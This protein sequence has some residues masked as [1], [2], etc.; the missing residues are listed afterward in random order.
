MAVSNRRQT[1][2]VSS[3]TD[4]ES[5][6]LFVVIAVLLQQRISYV[7]R[8]RWCVLTGSYF[9][10][11][12]D[13]SEQEVITA[14]WLGAHAHREVVT[15]KEL[16]REL[17]K[18]LV[19]ALLCG[20]DQPEPIDT[21]NLGAGTDDEAERSAAAASV[22]AAARRRRQEESLGAPNIVL[23]RPLCYYF[24]VRNRHHRWASAL[25]NADPP[26]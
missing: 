16:A 6:L 24:Q 23:N 1:L 26:R 3:C 2:V 13:H 19:F 15:N 12:A 20:D 5:V 18:K 22:A 8:R 11:F 21:E 25:M 14:V 17:G 7:W 4:I 9:V 10:V